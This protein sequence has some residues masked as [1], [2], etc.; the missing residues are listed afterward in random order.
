MYMKRQV[1]KHKIAQGVQDEI[2]NL[3][4]RMMKGTK[5]PLVEM[6]ESDRLTNLPM[7]GR[8][9][10]DE[11]VGS[12][13]AGARNREDEQ[14]SGI[15]AKST[16][17]IK[18]TSVL[19]PRA[20]SKSST[21]LPLSSLQSP[22]LLSTKMPAVTAVPGIKSILAKKIQNGSTATEATWIN[23][24]YGRGKNSSN[25]LLVPKISLESLVDLQKRTTEQKRSPQEGSG[26]N[27]AAKMIQSFMHFG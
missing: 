9:F 18:I 24:L 10:A 1:Q 11:V 2:N 26:V 22:T 19:S 3:E 13:E 5:M 4:A 14:G 16:D 6:T 23:L 20:V 21:S 17:A 12:I 25:R 15:G 8:L 27:P 7:E